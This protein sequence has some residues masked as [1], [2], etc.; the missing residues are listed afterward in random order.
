MGERKSYNHMARGDG[1]GNICTSMSSPSYSYVGVRP[2]GETPRGRSARAGY[3]PSRAHRQGVVRWCSCTR[4]RSPHPAE[5]WAPHGR[6][7]RLTEAHGWYPSSHPCPSP[8]RQAPGLW[9][10]R[11]LAERC[12]GGS[13]YSITAKLSKWPVSNLRRGPKDR[14]R[15]DEPQTC[16]SSGKVRVVHDGESGCS[17][18]SKT[19]RDMLF[20]RTG[21][22]TCVCRGQP[23]PF[24]H[25]SREVR[26][27][28]EQKMRL[29]GSARRYLHTES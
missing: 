19:T 13:G 6:T 22:R 16:S 24:P 17:V 25:R 5:S 11:G 9:R 27:T 18:S 20:S 28:E 23:R 15:T 29:T 14:A 26:D 12:Q 10:V 2:A 1:Q 21:C 8:N 4:Q 7:S 3:E